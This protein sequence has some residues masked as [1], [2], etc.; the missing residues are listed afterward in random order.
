V[1]TI[2][3]YLFA[4]AAVLSAKLVKKSKLK[5]YPGL[6]HGMS[7]TNPEQIN[8]DL[9]AFCKTAAIAEAD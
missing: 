6:P 7:T 5:I 4:D 1:T 9:F 2:R 8:A 3:S